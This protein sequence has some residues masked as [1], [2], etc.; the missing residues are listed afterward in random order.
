MINYRINASSLSKIIVISGL[1]QCIYALIILLFIFVGIHLP[2]FFDAKIGFSSTGQFRIYYTNLAVIYPLLGLSLYQFLYSNKEY[3]L[4]GLNNRIVSLIFFLISFFALFFLSSS[5]GFTL[6]GIFVIFA[7]FSFS[8]GSQLQRYRLHISFFIFILF[9]LLLIFFL[10]E[11]NYIN[12]I[13]DM[14]KSDDVSN[15]AR[16]D[17]LGFMI[18]DLKFWGQGLGAVV[19][20]YISSSDSPYGFELTFINTIHKFGVFSI[21][22]F[23][24]WIYMFYF[25]FKKCWRKKNVI[26]NVIMLSSLGYLFPAIGN[27]VLFHPSLVMLNAI[28]LYH[29]KNEKMN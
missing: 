6:G 10:V 21:V 12:I 20:G 28:V 3:K 19:P 15:V 4:L 7:I 9:T 11:F 5:K 1:F 13:T 2:S 24:N 22:L 27:P 14:F 17:Q 29:I 25:L 16:Y 18:A 23:Y 26:N 8:Y